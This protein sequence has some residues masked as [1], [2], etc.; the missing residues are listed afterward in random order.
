M[1]VA[2]LV[3]LEATVFSST[4]PL[5]HIYMYACVFCLSHALRTKVD[6]WQGIEEVMSIV[7]HNRRPKASGGDNFGHVH[8][9][10]FGDYKH[11]AE[12][13]NI[14]THVRHP[15]CLMYFGIF[16]YL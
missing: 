9:V 14:C 13:D 1:D 2:T 4:T 11:S 8:V 16:V 3:W 12:Q 15:P 7:D 5:E 10:L 6:I